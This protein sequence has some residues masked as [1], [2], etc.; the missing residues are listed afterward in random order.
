[1]YTLFSVGTSRRIDRCQPWSSRRHLLRLKSSFTGTSTTWE[2]FESTH[3]SKIRALPEVQAFQSL[4]AFLKRENKDT[5]R[6]STTTTNSSL[7]H[8]LDP[9]K[10]LL[11]LDAA[12]ATFSLHVHARIASLVGKGFYTIGPCG[13][14]LLSSAAMAFK[15]PD[16]TALHYRHTGI[17]IARQLHE[18]QDKSMQDLLLARARGYCVSK[19][20]PVTGG[21]H[22]SIG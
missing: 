7:K 19:Y 9:S 4:L 15:P 11:S 20:D 1:M 18:N 14:E 16:T 8:T 12:M 6:F 5:L 17:S 13:E 10:F 3:G 2:S 22:C 21:V